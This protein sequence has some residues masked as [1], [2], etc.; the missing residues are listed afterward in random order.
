M[1]HALDALGGKH[2]EIKK[3]TGSGSLYHNYKG[4][5]SINLMALV[6]ANSK[7][8]WCDLGLHA[9]CQIFNNSK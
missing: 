6:D 4:F 8:I 5:I 3:S 2:I 9:D 1:P 7:F